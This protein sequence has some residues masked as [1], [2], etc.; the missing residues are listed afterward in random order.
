MTDSSSPPN[1]ELPEQAVA[2]IGIGLRAPGAGD[3]MQLWNKLRDNLSLIDDL[4]DEDLKRAR[5]PEGMREH[6]RYI[7]RGGRIEGL[8][9]FDPEL[10]GFT[11]REAALMD[12][13][14]RHLCECTWTA[15]EDAAID[16]ARPPGP[17]GLFV[18][19]SASEYMLNNILPNRELVEETGLQN[20]F[21]LGNDR[22]FMTS[23]LAYALD[24]RGPCVGVQAACASGALAVHSACQSLLGRECRIAVAAAASLRVPQDAGYLY[25]EGGLDSPDGVC[26]TFDAR[27]AG[28]LPSAAVA[29][30]ALA[31]LEDA[32]AAGH[33]IYAV[34]RGTAVN[35]DGHR[36]VGY[37]APSV[38][39]PSQAIEEAMAVAGIDPRSIGYVEAHGTG[40]PFGDSIEV[41]ALRNAFQTQTSDI[42]FCVL[43]A[44]KPNL[45]HTDHASGLVSLVKAC[46]ALHTKTLPPLLNFRVPH[47]MLDLETSPFRVLTR[48]EHW[49]SEDGPRRAL[50][51]CLAVGGTNVHLVLEEAPSIF[52]A[53]VQEDGELLVLSAR[54]SE[55]LVQ[56]CRRLAAH[57]RAHPHETL[58]DIAHTL[59]LGRR[60]LPVR[61]AFVVGTEDEAL[62]ALEAFPGSSRSSMIPSTML[63][64]RAQ[65]FLAGSTL[66]TSLFETEGRQLLRLPT[67]PFEHR[68]FWIDPPEPGAELSV[69]RVPV[70]N[71]GAL[72]RLISVFTK[73]V[74]SPKV[75]LNPNL[76]YLVF[77][78]E[79]GF[80]ERAL[81]RLDDAGCAVTVV[82]MGVGPAL[83]R[84]NDGNYLIDC[85][86]GAEGFRELIGEL[87]AQD[88]LPDVLL[89]FWTVTSFEPFRSESARFHHNLERGYVALVG[90]AQGLAELDKKPAMRIAAVT[91]GC[92]SVG[93]EAVAT[94]EKAL[95]Y[96]PLAALPFE[97]PTVSTIAFDVDIPVGARRALLLPFGTKRWHD[98]LLD[99]L[100]AEISGSRRGLYAVRGRQ[101][102]ERTLLPSPAI[103]SD[104]KR[105]LRPG[106]TYLIV[107]GF[108]GVG[109]ALAEEI[110]RRIKPRLVLIG[111][112]P[113]PDRDYF[114]DWLADHDEHDP[115]SARIRQ[116]QRLEAAGAEVLALSADVCHLESMQSAAT[117]ISRRFGTLNGVFHAAGTL[118]EWL[119][120]TGTVSEAHDAL[121]AEV[122]GW[123]VLREV[124]RYELDFLVGFGNAARFSPRAGLS[125]SIAAAEFA[126]ANARHVDG[127]AQVFD[128][129][130]VSDQ[131]M[132]ATLARSIE[133]EG[134]AAD[135]NARALAAQIRRGVPAQEVARIVLDDL[136]S[137]T[138]QSV[139][140]QLPEPL[141]V[142]V[143]VLSRSEI[144][145]DFVEPDAG[146]ERAIAKIWA[147]A[148]NL[149]R[150]GATDNFFDLGG[151]SLS[152]VRVSAKIKA[153]YGIPVPLALLIKAPTV[154]EFA[155]LIE[156]E[157]RVESNN[158]HS[159]PPPPRE[160]TW[161][162]LVAM[163]PAG[164]RPPLF[165]V[166]G[167]GG[168]VMNL[169]HLAISLGPD[170]PVYGLQ[171]RGVDGI[172]APHES[173][174]AM[175]DEYVAEVRKVCPRGPYLLAGFSAGGALIIHMALK[176][177]QGGGKVAPLFFLDAWNPATKG[178]DWPE[179]VAEHFSLLQ[180]LGPRYVTMLGRR[181]VEERSKEFLE[182]HAP[183]V[184]VRLWERS[185]DGGR[186]EAAWSRAIQGYAPP[187]Y[188][189]DAVLFRVRTNR[190]AGDFEYMRDEHNGWGGVIQ[191]A[192]QVIEVPG[193]HASLLDEPHV[194]ALAQRVRSS[195]DRALRSL[196][197]ES[198]A[199][200]GFFAG[201]RLEQQLPLVEAE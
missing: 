77:A 48:A 54:T 114:A 92:L 13:Q 120:A 72:P 84:D 162:S 184:A 117:Q 11:P 104:N 133:Q 44:N 8:A 43:G 123:R 14:L 151:S 130:L 198:D 160:Y 193:N 135:R 177:Q 76:R 116:I 172:M 32:V 106:G 140:G 40:T 126:D 165:C 52:R 100:F 101:L 129:G 131:G 55:A 49:A 132:Y 142:G 12:P 192:L 176:L 150:V 15:L 20:L 85:E 64:A 81:A 56:S 156:V 108:G 122:Y 51:N 57:M 199:K 141:H 34:I 80:S 28:T 78:E 42:G 183:A 96:G 95:M 143:N 145:R 2:V 18:G 194:R 10:F 74:A 109:R 179:R 39:G 110:T 88:Q 168:N 83:A 37:A 89:Y 125:A 19:T 181:R 94:P 27:A 201:V 24:L 146:I 61:A 197:K 65:T 1:A 115:V 31:R 29:V 190:A 169:R 173:I 170:Q 7:R 200:G 102:Y 186:V 139:V 79:S 191:G 46:L 59:R 75:E 171:S 161:S 159:V 22:D 68:A 25:E 178:L 189:G 195:L 144:R 58:A 153:A 70:T 21:R 3:A 87:A 47:P 166:G 41:N 26:R 86:R 124:I 185:L 6:P 196:E 137:S 60:E 97:E 188:P 174:D 71:Q 103:P 149:D 118:D 163:Q 180:E 136:A 98:R 111:R 113:I 73:S 105:G 158:G 107:G 35:N 155:K 148:L 134:T 164:H 30:V 66:D 187:N 33:Q 90:L 4:S 63:A 17:I 91:N 45:G 69:G 23:R 93:G 182:R 167:S 157:T 62:E 82:R 119:L 138:A 175:V 121:A 9:N 36:K 147:Q 154:R 5:V 127:M 16:P 67:Y 38:D 50:V 152:A 112:T 53:P 99:R 128:L